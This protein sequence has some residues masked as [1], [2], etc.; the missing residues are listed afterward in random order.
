MA[1]TAPG[2]APATLSATPH[3]RMRLGP[4]HSGQ[5][6]CIERPR[7]FPGPLLS[8]CLAPHG[9]ADTGGG[10]VVWQGSTTFAE[11]KI[12]APAV[13]GQNARSAVWQS[14][15][16]AIL[17]KNPQTAIFLTATADLRAYGPHQCGR[18]PA[19]ALHHFPGFFPSSSRTFPLDGQRCR[20][21][22][23]N[24]NRTAPCAWRAPY[25]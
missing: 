16:R 22:C 3:I 19:A 8:R 1:H 25:A 20:S 23:R 14:K 6:Q 2:A 24:R 9:G 17:A 4:F 21:H 18:T 15:N 13:S 7:S 12:S 5:A 10:G 11:G